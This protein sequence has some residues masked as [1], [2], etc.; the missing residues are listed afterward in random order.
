MSYYNDGMGF[1][2]DD[3]SSDEAFDPR[4]GMQDRPSPRR[5]FMDPPSRRPSDRDPM[6][7]YPMEDDDGGPF[8]HAL[9][10]E[11]EREH[12]YDHPDDYDCSRYNHRSSAPSP[13][14]PR[15]R[16]FD[17]SFAG[18][19]FDL[20]NGMLEEDEYV[21]QRPGDNVSDRLQGVWTEE[22]REQRPL[23]YEGFPGGSV[24][25][26]GRGPW[27]RGRSWP[28]W[29]ES[30]PVGAVGYVGRN[31]GMFWGHEEYGGPRAYPVT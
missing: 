30:M 16:G 23:L 15:Q 4:W 27:P 5:G 22:F 25:T 12:Y 26:A 1:L 13:E 6:A 31:E 7:D 18:P 29:N 2:D 14:T 20:E 17:G 10:E 28:G 11:M 19:G 24:P 21:G 8:S 9:Y 3:A